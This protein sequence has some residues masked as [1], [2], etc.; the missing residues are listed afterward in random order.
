M[1]LRAM[2]LY[3]KKYNYLF[4]LLAFFVV[5]LPHVYYGDGHLLNAGDYAWPMDFKR[6]FDL[7]LSTWDDSSVFGYSAPR[8]HAILMYS[9]YGSLL[10][11]LDLSSANIQS[12]YFSVAVIVCLYGTMQLGRLFSWSEDQSI[13]FSLL[14][15]LSSISLHYWCADHGLNVF[16]YL[17]FPA[18]IALALKYLVTNNFWVLIFFFLIST[19]PSFSNPAFFVLYSGSLLFFLVFSKSMLSNKFNSKYRS[20]ALI[21]FIY[22]I[23]NLPWMLPFINDIQSAFSGASN[24]ISGLQPDYFIAVQTSSSLFYSILGNGSGLW[25]TFGN[26]APGIPIRHWGDFI[27]SSIFIFFNILVFLIALLPIFYGKKEKRYIIFLGVYIILIALISGLKYAFPINLITELFLDIPG[28][29]RGFRA[30]FM[31]FGFLL[32]FFVSLVMSYSVKTPFKVVT[33]IFILLSSMSFIS[34]VNYS[35]D[36]GYRA[37]EYMAVPIEYELLKEISIS[38]NNNFPPSLVVLPLNPSSYNLQLRW[39]YD[40]GFTGAEFLRTLWHGPTLNYHRGDSDS[41]KIIE[42]CD[43]HDFSSDCIDYLQDRGNSFFLVRNDHIFNRDVNNYVEQKLSSMVRLGLLKSVENNKYFHL[44]QSIKNVDNSAHFL[45]I[46]CPNSNVLS[47]GTRVNGSLISIN[48]SCEDPVILKSGEHIDRWWLCHNDKYQR[49]I[50]KSIYT[51]KQQISTFDKF[52]GDIGCGV[53][54]KSL[55]TISPNLK[56]NS[57]Y[58]VYPSYIVFLLGAFISLA[59]FLIITILA[60]VKTIINRIYI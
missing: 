30:L 12:I 27:S 22:L 15:L 5:I 45:S 10:A 8:Q 3:N 39:G 49:N 29:E 60:V 57:E 7:T 25:T 13:A 16:A 9:I 6:M 50:N 34:A 43:I 4:L 14:Y 36:N 21:V 33:Y 40:S 37:P 46:N 48:S 47:S 55:T 56:G 19:N 32:A 42:N 58:I 17:L 31:K 11:Q 1:N 26:H 38:N 52:I 44:F 23:A 18:T 20:K 2:T 24:V 35:E 54:Y 59:I 28:F 51:K 41:L 53:A